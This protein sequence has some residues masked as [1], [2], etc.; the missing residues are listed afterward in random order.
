MG[1]CEDS[2]ERDFSVGD[3]QCLWGSWNPPPHQYQEIPFLLCV[4]VCLCSCVYVSVHVCM[5]LGRGLFSDGGHTVK[6]AEPLL[7]HHL[8]RS[9]GLPRKEQGS[10]VSIRMN[11][12]TQQDRAWQVP[13]L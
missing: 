2:L 11:C 6:E 8:L 10:Q 12:H 7:V 3:A 13:T 5:G 4:H 1:F 9:T